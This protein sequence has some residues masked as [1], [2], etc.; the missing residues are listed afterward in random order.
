MYLLIFCVDMAPSNFSTIR[1][2]CCPCQSYRHYYGLSDSY[3]TVI[4]L[5]FGD[6]EPTKCFKCCNPSD[7][8]MFDVIHLEVRVPNVL[9]NWKNGDYIP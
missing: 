1:T 7:M 6:D 3:W 8:I 4:I 9:R 2:I 5:S